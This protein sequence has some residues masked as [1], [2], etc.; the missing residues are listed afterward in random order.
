ML[1][2]LT[3]SYIAQWQEENK[4]EISTYKVKKNYWKLQREKNSL[5]CSIRQGTS[6]GL[7]VTAK[8]WENV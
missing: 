3:Y 2:I 8:T 1:N 4:V 7:A 6:V 5:H